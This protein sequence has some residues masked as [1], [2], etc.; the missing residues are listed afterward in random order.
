MSD[1]ILLLLTKLRDL[2]AMHLAQ[3]SAMPRTREFHPSEQT[4]S[5]QDAIVELDRQIARR[6]AG[7]G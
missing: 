4:Q 5:C 6:V 1:P 3:I 2:Y 7:Q